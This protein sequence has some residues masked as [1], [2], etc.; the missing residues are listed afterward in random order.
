MGYRLLLWYSL[1]P[2]LRGVIFK[3]V[4]IV[5][6]GKTRDQILISLRSGRRAKGATFELITNFIVSQISSNQILIFKQFKI[7]IVLI[8]HDG[9]QVGINHHRA[10]TLAAVVEEVAVVY[11]VIRGY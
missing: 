10:F 11:H 9:K 3:Q 5:Q 7:E 1:A 4:G 6:K 2:Q 8:I